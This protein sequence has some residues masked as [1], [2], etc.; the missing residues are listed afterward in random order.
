LSLVEEH[1]EYLTCYDAVNERDVLVA[2]RVELR[3]S[4]YDG[5]TIDGIEYVYESG[6][7]RTLTRLSDGYFETHEV[8]PAYMLEQDILAVM[9]AAVDVGVEIPVPIEDPPLDP[10]RLRWLELDLHR[11]WTRVRILEPA[12]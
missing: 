10:I 11:D 4:T 2:K 7:L 12:L 1:D 8:W 3:R 9:L 6:T 5:K